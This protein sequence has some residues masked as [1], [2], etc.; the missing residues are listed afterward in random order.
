M[1]TSTSIS[2]KMSLITAVVIWMTLLP[3]LHPRFVQAQQVEETATFRV[4]FDSTWSQTTHP[5]PNGVT[6]FPSNPHLSGLIGGS[7]NGNV[8]FWQNGALA[9]LGIKN[10]AELGAKTDLQNEVTSAISAG[11]A[12]AVISG[13]GIPLSPASVSINSF[14]MNKEYPLITLT[15]MI[16]PS[17]D[18]FV[19]VSGMSLLDG[20]GN[21]IPERVVMLYP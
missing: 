16:A 4:T 14:S 6:S 15:S 2:K 7:H 18:W 19:G 11:N 9:S 17:P 5:H 12:N 20:Q 10:M 8:T 13:G 1:S 21:W 3:A